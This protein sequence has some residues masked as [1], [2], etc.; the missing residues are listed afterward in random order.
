MKTTRILLADDH[1]LLRAGLRNLIEALPGVAEVTEAENGREAIERIA[2]SH[3]DLVFMDIAMPGLNGLE[4]LIHIR[5]EFPKTLVVIFTMH[6]NEEYVLRAMRSG[7]TGYLLK[8]AK[9]SELQLAIETVLNGETYMCPRI[10]RALD[11]YLGRS[12]QSTD[13]LAQLTP[14]QRETLQLLAEGQ[15]TKE[16]A[17]TL[18]ISPK[19]VEMHR[20]QLMERLQI[21]DLAGLVRYAIRV[22]LV[23]SENR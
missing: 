18:K 6:A 1:A 11:E 3:P 19:T 9:P 10:S 13:P 20:A 4:A 17:D 12:G 21:R 23:D 14:R 22:G 15:S 2:S 8:V 5:K 16:I 7:A